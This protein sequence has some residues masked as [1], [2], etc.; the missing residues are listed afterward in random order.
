MEVF[1][2]KKTEHFLRGQDSTL[3]RLIHNLL[4]KLFLYHHV[5]FTFLIFSTIFCH[6]Y[7]LEKVEIFGRKKSP[8]MSL[9]MI[10][11]SGP[12]PRV[13]VKVE[14]RPLYIPP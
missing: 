12:P 11:I 10:K 6:I 4:K 14:G 13:K 5:G 2:L 8:S 7:Y 1:S 9:K 3:Q